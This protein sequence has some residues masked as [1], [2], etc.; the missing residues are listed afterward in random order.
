MEQSSA[1]DNIINCD[2]GCWKI[3]LNWTT[4][5][6]DGEILLIIIFTCVKYLAMYD[7]VYNYYFIY[8]IVCVH[9]R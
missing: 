6:V 7:Y 5:V 8:L 9:S 3:I 2:K 1:L 4:L